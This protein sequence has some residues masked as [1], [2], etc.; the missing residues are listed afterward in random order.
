MSEKVKKTKVVS[1]IF[2][3]PFKTLPIK[4][5]VRVPLHH[6]LQGTT[7]IYL[8]RNE[9]ITDVLP[10][11]GIQDSCIISSTLLKEYDQHYL[12]NLY[13]QS[14][15]LPKNKYTSTKISKNTTDKGKRNK[16]R[17]SKYYGKKHPRNIKKESYFKVITVPETLENKKVCISKDGIVKRILLSERDK[18][19]DWAYTSKNK[20]KSYIKNKEKV[21]YKDKISEDTILNNLFKKNKIEEDRQKNS[22]RNT[23]KSQ[24]KNRNLRK[25]RS[26]NSNKSKRVLLNNYKNIYLS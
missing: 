21:E 6:Y 19:S 14:S 25:K 4:K 15:L 11:M 9:T 10:K 16:N 12:F 22:I 2:I 20:Y 24:I 26:K 23:I 7:K 17:T 1:I 18:Y 8:S 3:L 5:I 13:K